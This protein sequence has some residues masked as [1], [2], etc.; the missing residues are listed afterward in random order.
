[1]PVQNKQERSEV[2]SYCYQCVAG[3]D[4]LKVD[5]QNGVPFQV[6][7]NSAASEIHPAGGKVC[8]KAYG[9]IQKTNN[10]HR[11]LTPMMRT[12]PKKGRNEDPGFQ[13]VSWDVAL[14]AIAKKLNR[15][16]SDGLIDNSGFPRVAASFGGGGTPTAY[17]GTF[18]AFLSAWGPVDMSLVADK[19]LSAITPNTF[20]GSSGTVHSRFA[21]THLWSNSSCLLAPMSKLQAAFA[22]SSGMLM[23]GLGVQSGCRLSRICR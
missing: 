3:P 18:P 22:A 2:H 10:P 13:P 6:R 8:V 4:L 7:P 14:D 16:R 17:M 1:M 23:P 11:I 19:A 5:V 12:N 9:L 21:R 15:V 20:M